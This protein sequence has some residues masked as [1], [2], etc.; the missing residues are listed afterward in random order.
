MILGLASGAL[1][2]RE[3][4]RSGARIRGEREALE[5]AFGV[6][7]EAPVAGRSRS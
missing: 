6:G 7:A 3:A 4:V 2:L 5:R 1:S